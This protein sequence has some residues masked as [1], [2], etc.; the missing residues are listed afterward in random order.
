MKSSPRTT[1]KD[2][3]SPQIAYPRKSSLKPP[4]ISL[5]DQLN[6]NHSSHEN[7]TFNST[8]LEVVD[9]LSEDKVNEENNK[10]AVP[11]VPVSGRRKSIV[12]FG[13]TTEVNFKT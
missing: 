10:T 2:A 4:K 7:P 6:N 1:S 9:E 12:T 8:E 5:S 11:V 3:Q 13:E